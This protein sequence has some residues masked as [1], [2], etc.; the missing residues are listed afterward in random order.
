MVTRHKSPEVPGFLQKYVDHQ[1]FIEPA[2]ATSVK[3]LRKIGEKY[4]IDGI[5]NV[6][7]GF[8]SRAESPVPHLEGYFN[9]LVAHFRVAEEWKVNR[10]MFSSTGGVYLGLPGPV[11]EEQPIPLAS[12]YPLLSYQKIVELASSEFGKKTGISSVSVRLMGMFGPWQDPAF[13][14]LPLRL[15]HAAVSGSPADL[16]EVFLAGA[17]DEVDLLYIKDMARALAL[18]QTAEDL[19]HD[20]YNVGSGRLT[21]NRELVAAV[22]EVVPEFQVD[23]PPGRTLELPLMETDRLRADTGFTPAFDTQSAVQNYAEWLKAGNPK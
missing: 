9:M 2:D 3:D 11:N 8:A 17:E 7:G 5:V 21:P 4:K 12:P 1:V 20:T 14:S 13:P 18:L 6:G 23:R 15:V 22:R 10:L 16:D 19:S